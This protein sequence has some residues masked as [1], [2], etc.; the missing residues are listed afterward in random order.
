MNKA[1]AP[2]ASAAPQAQNAAAAAGA[3]LAEMQKSGA[4][5]PPVPAAAG[6]S[7][8]KVITV[9]QSAVPA[10]PVSF[11]LIPGQSNQGLNST[12]Q[13]AVN[14]NNARDLYSVPLQVQY[15]NAKLTLMNV[16]SGNFLGKDG[17]AISVVHRDDGSGGLTVVAA[18]PPGTVGVEGSGTVCV[19][20]FQAKAVGDA[21][22]SITRP[23]AMNTANQPMQT[24]G[25]AQALVHIK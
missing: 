14:I 22:I 17:Q 12:F 15:D 7:Q 16:D 21:N 2:A 18:R 8:G 20:T 3:A 6:P 19:I 23:G 9:P 1:H 24:T 25:T 4:A 10:V 13:I 5:N 11:N